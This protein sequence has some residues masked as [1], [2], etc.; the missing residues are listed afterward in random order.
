VPSP[1][2]PDVA[3]V[4][5]DG[6]VDHLLRQTVARI[7]ALGLEVFAVIDH[8]GEAADVGLAL[9]DTKLVLFG[10]PTGATALMLAHPAVALD[11]PLK[12]LIREGDDGHA[13]VSYHRPGDLARRHGLT[14]DETAALRIV[15]TISSPTGA[16][17]DDH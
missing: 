15:E 5:A 13:I 14:H 12:V 3:S 8:S 2:P 10:S 1:D 4:P 7:E 6:S 17:H 9:P 16:N 11:L